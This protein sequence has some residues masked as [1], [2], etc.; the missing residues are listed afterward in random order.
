MRNFFWVS[1]LAL[2]LS[3]GAQDSHSRWNEQKANDWWR[4]HPSQE[5]DKELGWAE[6]LGMNTM[7]VFLHDLLWQQNPTGFKKRIDEFL[8]I[9]SK[10]HIRPILVLFDSCWDPFPSSVH[11]ILPFPAY[12]IPAGYKV[13]ARQLSAIRPRKQ[14]LKLILRVWLEPS[15]TI[16]VFSPGISGMSLQTSM[17]VLTEKSN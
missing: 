1:V 17:P 2:V 7:R 8:A 13:L 10:H 9:S 3:A 6:S 4:G 16:H 14:D 15:P 12:T 5:I 11:S